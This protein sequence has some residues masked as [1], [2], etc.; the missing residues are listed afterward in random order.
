MSDADLS[1]R[2]Y[3]DPYL[4]D[5]HFK[6][7]RELLMYLFSTFALFSSLLHADATPT[8]A[9]LELSEAFYDWDCVNGAVEVNVRTHECSSTGLYSMTATVNTNRGQSIEVKLQNDTPCTETMWVAS[10]PGIACTSKQNSPVTKISVK[11]QVD[12][13]KW[14]EA[15]DAQR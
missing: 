11:A 15:L 4:H 12:R 3:T 8:S 10:V 13:V 7:T 5:S 9:T 6:H 1:N 2:K 14:K